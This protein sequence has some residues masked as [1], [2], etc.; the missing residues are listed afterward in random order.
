MEECQTVNTPL[1]SQDLIISHLATHQTVLLHKHND[2]EFFYVLNGHCSHY[3]NGKETKITA[4]NAFL[5]FPDDSHAITSPSDDFIRRYISIDRKFFER[6][7][8]HYQENFYD[9]LNMKM[10]R[11]LILNNEQI[12]QLENLS[13]LLF[14]KKNEPN[15]PYINAIA[16]AILNLFLQ[17]EDNS[18]DDYIPAW[19]IKLSRNLSKPTEFHRSIADITAEYPYSVG[20]ICRMFKKYFGV[21]MGDYFNRKKVLYAQTLIQSTDMS[22]EQICNTI[23]FNSVSYFYRLYKKYFSITPA[24]PRKFDIKD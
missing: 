19:L 10:V 8:A 9:I 20:Y 23:G 1:L 2:I 5:L 7:C 12:Q 15:N 3:L 17:A 4:G 22:I 14:K 16:T 13:A 11:M 6:V 18:N 21:S 24:S